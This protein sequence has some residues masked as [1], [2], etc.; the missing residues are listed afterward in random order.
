MKRTFVFAL[1]LGL[2]T[3]PAFAGNKSETIT[4]GATSKVGTSTLPAG[5]YKLTW[6]GTGA[7]VQ[8]ELVQKTVQRPAKATFAATF[9][10]KKNSYVTV[11]VDQKAGAQTLE[12]IQIHDGELVPA[13]GTSTG[14]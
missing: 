3:L 14:N 12:S 8:V 6:T 11:T 9:T 2:S 1:I 4:L 13:A 5:E 7:N 10:A